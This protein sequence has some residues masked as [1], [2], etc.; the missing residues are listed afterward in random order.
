MTKIQN[1]NLYVPNPGSSLVKKDFQTAEWGRESNSSWAI[2]RSSNPVFFTADGHN[3]KLEDYAK[4]SSVLIV[5]NTSVPTK[6]QLKDVH[7]WGINEVAN[8]IKVNVWSAFNKPQQYTMKPW[9]NPAIL[10]FL[11]LQFARDSRQDG[12]LTSHSPNCFYFRRHSSFN[13]AHFLLQ[14]T[15]WNDGS[16]FSEILSTL[17]LA[18]VLGYRK[19]FISANITD[20]SSAAYRHLSKII[21]F[22]D[23]NEVQVATCGNIGPLPKIDIDKA[24]KQCIL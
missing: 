17:K 21:P 6:E 4:G 8:Q 10:K 1:H 24:C 23:D 7:V 5:H 3:V 22:L 13:A 20:E 19:I 9:L 11:P 18:I 2:G 15:I 12:K 16:D 14:E